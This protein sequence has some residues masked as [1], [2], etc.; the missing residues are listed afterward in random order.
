MKPYLLD[1]EIQEVQSRIRRDADR[2]R[3]AHISQSDQPGMAARL[4]ARLGG[5]MV[6]QGTS[7]QARY[8]AGKGFHQPEPKA[9]EILFS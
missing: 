2:I 4:L 7:L 9:A 6:T 5:W 3:L 8:H 1:H